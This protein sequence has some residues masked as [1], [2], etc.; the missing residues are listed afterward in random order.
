[1]AR[2]AASLK[3]HSAKLFLAAALL[4]GGACGDGNGGTDA[5]GG[6][7][8][9]GAGG[10]GGADAGGRGGTSAGGRGG[11][12]G[13]AGTT[14]A[15]GDGTA[16]GGGASG[17]SGG[18]SGG[19]GGSSGGSGGTAGG[20]GGTTSR[21]GAGGGSAGA[22]GGNA[23][24][25]GGSAGAGGGSAGA[26]GGRGGAGG[27]AGSGGA[28]GGKAGSGGDGGGKAGTGGGGGAGGGKAGTGG[29]AGQK[30]GCGT[31]D[32][33]DTQYCDWQ[34]N[35]CGTGVLVT[36]M[37][38]SRPQ[39]CG[40]VF[41]PVC[42]CDGVVYSNPCMAAAAGQDIDESGSGCKPPSET[43]A[44]GPRFCNHATQY[45]EAMIGGPAG[46]AGSYGCHLLPAACG[47]TPTCACLAGTAQCGNC[48]MST[49]GDLTTR[50]LF[51]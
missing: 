5:G 13:S 4:I 1:M 35:R 48:Q 50:C 47:T 9:A 12:G 21:G 40:A 6:N 42:G 8:A 28:G 26:A 25:A 2:D 44:C 39:G 14:G 19:S 49:A 41:D 7:A 23:G 11:G 31:L 18:A 38:V 43:F 10:R 22:S 30:G 3:R 32:C 27:G 34:N 36:G 17:G 15:A 45:C 46:A 29:A 33:S 16:G 37:C 24:A 51:P 20:S